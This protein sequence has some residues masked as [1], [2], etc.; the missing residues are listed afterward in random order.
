MAVLIG[1]AAA[2]VLGAVLRCVQLRCREAAGRL[3]ACT[4][5]RMSVLRTQE[6]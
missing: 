3:R 5:V 2:M 1:I 4:R 6:E